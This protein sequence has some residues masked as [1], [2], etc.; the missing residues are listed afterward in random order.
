MQ[1]IRFHFAVPISLPKAFYSYFLL[2]S[3]PPVLIFLHCSLVRSQ[4][5]RALL[6]K[7]YISDMDFEAARLTPASIPSSLD[8]NNS[9]SSVASYADG[10]ALSSRQQQQQQQQPSSSGRPAG[11]L[12]KMF[13]KGPPKHPKLKP[14]GISSKDFFAQ[15]EAE[16]SATPLSSTEYYA[17]AK[18]VKLS[19]KLSALSSF[20]PNSPPK[21]GSGASAA[22]S[23][24]LTAARVSSQSSSP[25][26]QPK[27]R[28]AEG[29]V[30]ELV[31]LPTPFPQP[32][33]LYHQAPAQQQQ[34]RE[35]SPSHSTTTTNS[36]SDDGA[37]AGE[38]ATPL[39]SDS[40]SSR[41]SSQFHRWRP[42]RLKIDAPPNHSHA[43]IGSQANTRSP[44]VSAPSFQSSHHAISRQ[45]PPR[46]AIAPSSPPMMHGDHAGGSSRGIAAGERRKRGSL[47]RAKLS[48]TNLRRPESRRQRHQSFDQ[49]AIDITA[50]PRVYA[51]SPLVSVPS[52]APVS[53]RG[54]SATKGEPADV[55]FADIMHGISSKAE[56]PASPDA[57]GSADMVT[58]MVSVANLGNIDKDFLLTIQRNSAL[59][60][61][62]QRR[63]ETRRNT[64]SFL[65]T[66][67]ASACEQSWAKSPTS[68]VAARKNQSVLVAPLGTHA[69]EMHTQLSRFAPPPID[70]PTAACQAPLHYSKDACDLGESTGRGS[71]P[72][73]PSMH[74]AKEGGGHA[75]VLGS[76]AQRDRRIVD[77]GEI[78]GHRCSANGA[79]T[80]PRSRPPPAAASQPVRGAQGAAASG[81]IHGSSRHAA[82]P[83]TA[84][85]SVCGAS[86]APGS[87]AG[88][89]VGNAEGSNQGVHQR[90]H[91]V[92]LGSASSRKFA[93][94]AAIDAPKMRSPGA[95]QLSTSTHRGSGSAATYEEVPPV[96][97]LPQHV[98]SR[99]RQSH[100]MDPA[101]LSPASSR[102]STASGRDASRHAPLSAHAYDDSATPV[103][104]YHAGDRHSS[105]KP[106][107]S[108]MLPSSLLP[109]SLPQAAIGGGHGTSGWNA[110]VHKLHQY[111]MSPPSGHP[112]L[113]IITNIASPIASTLS[114][115]SGSATAVSDTS[116]PAAHQSI[117]SVMY[118]SATQPRYQH[119]Q[120]PAL[121]TG[122][123]KFSQPNATLQDASQPLLS[124]IQSPDIMSKSAS[125]LH[126][127]I[128]VDS[129]TPGIGRLF[130]PTTPSR[131]MPLARHRSAHDDASGIDYHGM[132]KSAHHDLPV[133]ASLV[134]DPMAR[135]KI[136]DQLASSRAF[137]K[138][139]EEDGEFTM[140]I[141]LTPTV[142]G[143]GDTAAAAAPTTTPGKWK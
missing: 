110:E 136:R 94:S 73:S 42:E 104:L 68:T 100:S 103:D 111:R 29:C 60:A 57:S 137:D 78:G 141:S 81:P 43:S 40:S 116:D 102:P 45:S 93:F 21:T 32:S 33:H 53:S 26:I 12:G 25:L 82:A 112:K 91:A 143:A 132:P 109:S 119:Q 86:Q 67:A 54:R 101:R 2:L 61:R 15:E 113:G 24:V 107:P 84:A 70:S 9:S 117:H 1:T 122:I 120:R 65:G 130:S 124:P 83:S 17:S 131:R 72:A 38:S 98:I 4:P 90:D 75:G 27:A 135:R 128:S 106:P 23:P 34:R 108:P 52:A 95:L 30:D 10:A 47:W 48:F 99:N 11:F 7:K 50:H 36:G 87:S 13:R 51:E 140:A 28:A 56:N 79:P 80:S 139:L 49:S 125:N 89:S 55:T 88:S 66:S 123:R 31:A 18:G 114:M 76:A 64:M 133:V 74:A 127:R 96:P 22:A 6:L 85:D 97:P 16:P 71:V 118:S 115:N 20:A 3:S 58:E 92:P 121:A 46:S 134:G 19:R 138:L 41:S 77:D 62:R 105:S 35:M 142:A 14:M 63:R 44:L 59:E 69:A 129:K 8:R 37:P 126:F 5:S 39:S